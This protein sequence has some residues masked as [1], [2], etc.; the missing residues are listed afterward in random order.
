M[1]VF[2]TTQ[3]TDSRNVS[4]VYEGTCIG[5]RN[6]MLSL[7]DMWKAAGSPNNR[8]P[9]NWIR[10][11]GSSFIEAVAV[12]H[13]LSHTQVMNVKSGKGGGTFAHWQIAMAYAKYLSPEF[14]MWCNTV[15]RAHMEGRIVDQPREVISI[16]MLREAVRQEVMAARQELGQ[17]WAYDL[18]R[19]FLAS[20]TILIRK[21][22]TAGT[23]WRE[24]GFPPVKG[25]AA[26]FGNRL[27]DLGCAMEHSARAEMGTTTARL[28]DP[29][30]ARAWVEN[31]GRFVIERRIAERRG[32]GVL[33]FV[34]KPTDE[35][36]S[37]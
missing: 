13:N 24:F 33:S 32:Q 36:G 8:E 37:Q 4:L 25:I 6:E 31:G 27:R 26:W 15:V 3:K 1:T 34:R 5:A 35:P 10:F 7:T 22:K 17:A 21:G 12:C 14:H 9:F 11:D 16:E 23:L 28:F 29:D 18:A 2:D 20:Q 19:S 30:K